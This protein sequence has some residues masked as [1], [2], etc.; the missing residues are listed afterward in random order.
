[1]EK[2][3]TNDCFLCEQRSP[4]YDK[5]STEELQSIK[6]HRITIR[7]K[8]GEVIQKQGTFMTHVIS[9]NSGLAK[10]YL[11]GDDQNNTILRIVKP[12][13][14]VGGPGIYY[15][16]MHHFTVSAMIDTSI[17]FIDLQIFRNILDQNK[18][19][20]NEFMKAFSKNVISVYGRL[21]LLTQKQLVGRMAYAILYLFEDVFEN[22]E[23][24]IPI[25]K[26]DL[27]DLSAIS[28]DVALKILKDF[29]KEGMIKLS[30][31]GIELLKPEALR[32][33]RSIG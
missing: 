20:S 27:A 24:I 11:E 28:K 9:L 26:M 30:K 3:E 14:F 18:E 5:L 17:C 23:I 12:S 25:S 2:C 22:K 6:D 8:A 4:M 1:M 15:D 21:M 32:M 7:Y 13:N 31:N 29:Q 10:L 33:I 16:Q 19:F